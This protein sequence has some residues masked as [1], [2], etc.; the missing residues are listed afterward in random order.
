MITIPGP[1][2]TQVLAEHMILKE[3]GHGS[4]D[5]VIMKGANSALCVTL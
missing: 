4:S 5:C 3:V 1:R 2:Q